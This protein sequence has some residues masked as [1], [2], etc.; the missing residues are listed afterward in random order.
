MPNKR[1][2][3]FKKRTQPFLRRGSGRPAAASPPA[4]RAGPSGLAVTDLRNLHG[5]LQ[6][7]AGLVTRFKQAAVHVTVAVAVIPR[8][9]FIRGVVV[10]VGGAARVGAHRLTRVREHQETIPKLA[11]EAGE[12]EGGTLLC[13]E[14]ERQ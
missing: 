10:P 4:L 3:A 7:L 14:E 9:A 2:A 12:D 13:K 5:Q 11:K 8:V 6:T 1:P